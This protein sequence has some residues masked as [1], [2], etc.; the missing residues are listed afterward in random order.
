MCLAGKAPLPQ[1]SWLLTVIFSMGIASAQRLSFGM[2]VGALVSEPFARTSI[3]TV[4]QDLNYERSAQY[5]PSNHRLTWGPMMELRLP[6]SFA[7][8][9]S[10]LYRRIDYIST[11]R[12]R[13]I[14]PGFI[15]FDVTLRVDTKARNLDLPVLM[16]YRFSGQRVRPFIGAGGAAR[17]VFG[18]SS[19]LPTSS[20]ALPWDSS[21]PGLNRTW[22]GGF[23][24]AAGLEWRMSKLRIAPE[25]RYFRW[26]SPSFQ[27]ADGA[28]LSPANQLDFLLSIAF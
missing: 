17:W 9:V 21:P 5:V 7:V 13:D 22:S 4:H 20:G 24:V 23:V 26:A 15:P 1:I 2:K 27:D 12:V 25:L 10:A 28:W 8:E 14:K 6:R 18:V 11:T 3:S 19:R 16:K